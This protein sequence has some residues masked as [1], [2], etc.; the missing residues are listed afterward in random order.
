[1][2]LE[3]ELERRFGELRDGLLRVGTVTGT[4]V[5]GKVIVSLGG[6][7]KTLSRITNYTPV[8]GHNVLILCIKPGA[9]FVLGTPA[10]S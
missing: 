5:G 6:E 1:V 2:A 9:W 7:S 4:A 3:D 10:L 8:I